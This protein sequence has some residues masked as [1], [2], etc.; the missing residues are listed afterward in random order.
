V[1]GR[2]DTPTWLRR[3]L[4]AAWILSLLFGGAILEGWELH[5]AVVKTIG[6]DAAPSVEAA[7]TIE[8]LVESIDASLVNELLLPPG[9]GGDHVRD[10]DRARLELGRHVIAAASN[11]TYGD[12]ERRPLER[13]Q[14][15]LGRYLMAA[16]AARSANDNGESIPM[17]DHY[18]DAYR[19][20]KRDLVPAAIALNDANETIL[21]GTYDEDRVH[22]R[23]LVLAT[24]VTGVALLAVLLSTQWFLFRR[25]RRIVNPGFAAATL[26]AAWTLVHA[27]GAFHANAEDVKGMKEDAY[28]SVAALLDSRANAYEANAA[29]SRW[30]LDTAM[31]PEHDATFT[32]YVS[33]LASFRDGQSFERVVITGRRRNAF[34]AQYVHQGSVG[35]A[36]G[37]AARDTVKIDGFSGALAKGLDNVTFPDPDPTKDEPTQSLETVRTFGVYVG[38]DRRIRKLEADGHHTEAVAFCLGSA[39]GKSDWAFVKFDESLGRWLALNQEWMGRYRDRAF[40]DIAWLPGFASIA[41][42]AVLALTFLGLRPRLAEYG[43]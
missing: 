31:R 6:V 5:R 25:F 26:I 41:S 20:L 7:H 3:A 4:A 17:L 10:F 22:A 43:A 38:L 9:Q 13:I 19:I 28:D 21:T 8:V 1:P 39:E 40:A 37:H 23:W 18:R 24:T 16:Q 42:L 34:F 11:I 36:A 32:G 2:S 27:T 30:L 12:A 33:R 29:E 15:A 35:A 14:D